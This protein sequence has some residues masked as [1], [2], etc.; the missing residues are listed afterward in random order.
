MYPLFFCGIHFGVTYCIFS[1]LNC[2]SPKI[3]RICRI[4]IPK[5][6]INIVLKSFNRYLR[7]LFSIFLSRKIL[8]SCQALV[9]AEFWGDTCPTCFGKKNEYVPGELKLA[10]IWQEKKTCIPTSLFFFFLGIHNLHKYVVKK[11][12]MLQI[13][14]ICIPMHFFFQIRGIHILHIFG[15][16]CLRNSLN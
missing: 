2:I 16:T 3:C 11:W 9:W 4:C 1:F 6:G 12:K 7:K 10:H 14:R 15:D 8:N 5:D 13:C